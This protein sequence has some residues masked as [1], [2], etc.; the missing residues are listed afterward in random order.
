MAD[1]LIEKFDLLIDMDGVVAKWYPGLLTLYQAQYPDRPYVKPEDVTKF[2]V[3]ELYPEEHRDD[4]VAIARQK[5]FYTFLPVMEGAKEALKDIEENCL[6]FINPF[7]CTSPEVEYEDLMCHSEKVQWTNLHFG[8][9]WV[10]NTIITKDKTMV[11]GDLLI[12][13][14]PA[15]KGS[16]KPVWDHLHYAQPY[17]KGG[18]LKKQNPELGFTWNEWPKLR[19]AIRVVV[20]GEQE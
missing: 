11:I 9:F 15:I 6:D 2:Y 16:R 17:N 1:A 7:F 19:E 14:K 20:Y 4:V 18:Q 3:E 10:K 12:D 13:D 5:G 8:P